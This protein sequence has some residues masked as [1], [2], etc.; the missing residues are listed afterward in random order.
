MVG[1]K[2]AHTASDSA[3]SESELHRE[4]WTRIGHQIFRLQHVLRASKGVNNLLVLHIS[5]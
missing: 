2:G 1:E 4:L 5:V 3:T